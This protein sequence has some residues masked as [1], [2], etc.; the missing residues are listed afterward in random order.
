MFIMDLQSKVEPHH[1][2]HIQD[3]S[4]LGFDTMLKHSMSKQKANFYY[5]IKD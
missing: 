3:F 5:Y 2:L 4:S 1:F